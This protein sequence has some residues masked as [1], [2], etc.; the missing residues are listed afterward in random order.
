MI[1]NKYIVKNNENKKF[2]D[3][4]QSNYDEH[5]NKFN[6]YTVTIIWKKMI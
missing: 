3:V 2:K 1:V 5:K 6:E 4:L